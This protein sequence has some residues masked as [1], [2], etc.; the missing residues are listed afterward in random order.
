MTEKILARRTEVE[1]LFDGADITKEIMPYLLSMTYTDNEEGEADD[2]KIEL[3]DRES[4]W[5]ESWLNEAIAAASAA[6]LKIQAAIL[7]KYWRVGEEDKLLPCGTFELDD[8]SAQGPPATVSISGTALPFSSQ[9]RQTLK[10]KA[11]ESYKLSGIAKEIASANGMTCMYEAEFDPFYKRKEQRKKSDI[12]FLEKLCQDAG[13]SLKA[14]DSMIVLFDQAAYEKKPPVM[15][16][17]R[18]TGYIDY[19]L[20]TG[21]ADTQYA[22]CRV[23][24]VD[25]EGKCFE[26]TAKTEDYN[27]DDSNNQQLEITAKVYSADEAK[28]LAEKH[29]RLHNKFSKT[30]SFTLPGDASL[31]SGITLTLEGFGA[32]DGKYII[33]RAAHTVSGSYTTK[34]ELRK[35]LEGY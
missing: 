30:A 35:V 27:E 19:S 26:G 24:Y 12:K 5:M 23:S 31:V 21:A 6:K 22:S 11:W 13:I 15:T 17:R 16:I 10:S 34:I 4:L 29:L 9:I 25:S 18:G 7:P 32:W 33:S 14:T 20:S 8:V 28:T 3:Q 2:L 1:I